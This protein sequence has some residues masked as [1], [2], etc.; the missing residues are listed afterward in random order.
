[1]TK[2]VDMLDAAGLIEHEKARPSSPA[3][4]ER[5]WQSRFRAKPEAMRRARALQ[6]EA[7][8]ADLLLRDAEGFP[9]PLPDTERVGRMRKQIR[10]IND[11]LGGVHMGGPGLTPCGGYMNTGTGVLV[12]VRAHLCRIFNNDLNHGGRA[13][14]LYQN[15]P[16]DV[17][18]RCTL[19]GAPVV[20]ADHKCLHPQL[21]YAQAGVDFDPTRDDAYDVPGWQRQLVKTAFSVLV[22]ASSPDAARSRI[23]FE[24]GKLHGD[25]HCAAA[26]G[27]GAGR[28]WAWHRLKEAHGREADALIA[29][30]RLRHAPIA[31]AFGSG[32]GLRLQNIDAGMTL[33]VTNTLLKRGIPTLPIHDENMAPA[34]YE[35]L[36]QEV[37]AD[38]LTKAK[39]AL[40]SK[41]GLCTPKTAVSCGVS[42]ALL[43]HYGTSS[44][45]ALV[46]G[47]GPS[48]QHGTATTHSPA[49]LSDEKKGLGKN[50]PISQL[51]AFNL[52]PVAGAD[53]ALGDYR[54]GILP[55][56]A[57]A[58]VRHAIRAQGLTQAKLAM[59]VGVSR[60]QLV[61]ALRGRFGLSEG[62]ARALV[63]WAQA[64]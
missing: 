51:Q 20:R 40:M 34:N 18:E 11:M 23:C 14:A 38:A 39:N 15:L 45:V 22:N 41:A 60:P 28:H 30:I 27:A 61:N 50:W 17:R 32:A 31:H 53:E 43:S 64:A 7:I 37:M 49:C 24:L 25:T 5:R 16:R 57:R 6:I 58:A 26:M 19:N 35:S 12:P 55:P 48:N 10:H 1:V 54:A 52:F 33:S 44:R 8:V 46:A 56:P 42:G 3:K 9:V 47:P 36:L 62:P 2:A 13:Y 29:A 21:L 63:Q 59:C 4:V